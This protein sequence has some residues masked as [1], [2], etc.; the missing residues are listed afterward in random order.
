MLVAFIVRYR[1]LNGSDRL[2][3]LVALALMVGM[4]TFRRRLRRRQSGPPDAST[5]SGTRTE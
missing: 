5:G 1:E 3:L 2:L 4:F